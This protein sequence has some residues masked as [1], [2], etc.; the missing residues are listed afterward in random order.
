MMQSSS[1]IWFRQMK[2]FFAIAALF[3]PSLAFW[4]DFRM[5]LLLLSIYESKIRRPESTQHKFE[6][7]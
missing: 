5:A 1:P 7:F 3:A 2:S 4:R 6:I